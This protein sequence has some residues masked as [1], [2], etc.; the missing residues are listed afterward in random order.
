M[1][2][3]GSHNWD[4]VLNNFLNVRRKEFRFSDFRLSGK[5]EKWTEIKMRTL[6]SR[7]LFLI[8]VPAVV[9]HDIRHPVIIKA[10]I[11]LQLST[12]PKNYFLPLCF[13]Q[14]RKR[15][16]SR[17]SLWCMTWWSGGRSFC[18]GLCQKMS[19]KNSN[20]KSLPKLTMVT[21]K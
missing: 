12:K 6:I 5:M 8:L 10:S 9:Q 17:Y 16:S 13:R 15:G 21:S 1:L 18:P 11:S 3:F 19:L 7:V 20:R 4:S 2:F 14:I